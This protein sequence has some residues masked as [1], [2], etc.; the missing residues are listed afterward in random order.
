MSCE[1]ALDVLTV[2]VIDVF[3]DSGSQLNVTY[4]R[5]IIEV[6]MVNDFA[7]CFPTKIGT[8]SKKI[9]E[10]SVKFITEWFVYV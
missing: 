10:L 9:F 4:G 3:R 5:N 2:G 6:Q 7:A 8:P 1:F